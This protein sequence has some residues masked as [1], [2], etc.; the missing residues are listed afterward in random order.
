LREQEDC[1]EIF[2]ERGWDQDLE[3][4]CMNHDERGYQRGNRKGVK[5]KESESIGAKNIFLVLLDSTKIKL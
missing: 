3:F 5:G 2:I 4:G 1:R